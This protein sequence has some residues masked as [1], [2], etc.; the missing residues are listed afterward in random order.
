MYIGVPGNLFAFACRLS[1]HRGFEGYV[2]FTSKT[3]LI[4]HYKDN[5]GAE[6]IGAQ[7]MIINKPAALRLIN[8]YFKE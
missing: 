8:K 1:F 5:L 3:N 7:L 6:N 2:A 4:N